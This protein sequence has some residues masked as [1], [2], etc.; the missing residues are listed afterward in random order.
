[1]MKHRLT[2]FFSI[3]MIIFSQLSA[4]QWPSDPQG[5]SDSFSF[6]SEGGV[7]KGL[8]FHNSESVKPFDHGQVV[9]QYD[10]DPFSPSPLANSSLLVL[11]HENGFQSIYRGLPSESFATFSDSISSSDFLYRGGDALEKYFFTIRDARLGRLVNPLLLLPGLND[12]VPPRLLGMLLVDSNGA[13]FQIFPDRS[14]PA[15]VYKAF[16]HVEDRFNSRDDLV[17]MPFSVSLYNL[18]T[19]LARRRLDSL[20]QRGNA[21]ALQ[22]G[23]PVDEIFNSSGYLSLGDIMLNSGTASLEV[24]MEDFFGNESIETFSFRVL[25]Q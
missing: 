18:G 15:G 22:D 12:S 9:Y 21:I 3:Q 4:F 13:E 25:R 5:L 6:P 19:L 16:I 1:M 20:V 23:V 7:F 17:V 24:V 2:V 8:S 10:P 11:E 14:V